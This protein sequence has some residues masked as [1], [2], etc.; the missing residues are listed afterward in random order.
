MRSLIKT[1]NGKSSL[2]SWIIEHFPEDYQELEYCDLCCGGC[3]VFLTKKK[4]VKET[5]VDCDSG[6]ANIL[7]SLRDESKIFIRKIQQVEYTEAVFEK[8]LRKSAKGYRDYYEE[9]VNEFILRNMSRNGLKKNFLQP[10]GPDIGT[11]LDVAERLQ[12]T[13]ILNERF[14]DVLPVWNEENTFIFIDPPNLPESSKGVTK[15][16]EMSVEEH[17]NLLSNIADARAK[18]MLCG[19]DCVLY[20]KYLSEWSHFKKKTNGKKHH[21]IWINY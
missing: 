4:S 18:V 21:S 10:N 16:Y 13:T 7:K 6:V 11:L 1:Y 14:Q 15:D 17:I 12:N 19:F 9:G 20:K 8:A 2:A 3:S 5:L